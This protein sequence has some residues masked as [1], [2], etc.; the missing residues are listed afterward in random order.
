LPGQVCPFWTSFGWGVALAVPPSLA[1][2]AAFISLAGRDP[3]VVCLWETVGFGAG[4]FTFRI[5]VTFAWNVLDLLLIMGALVGLSVA[6]AG[7]GRLRVVA[8]ALATAGVSAWIT[9]AGAAVDRITRLAQ[10]PGLIA[11]RDGEGGRVALARVGRQLVLTIDGTAESVAPSEEVAEEEGLLPAVIHP[12]PRSFVV[13]GDPLGTVVE[14]LLTLG[15]VSIDWVEAVPGTFLALDAGALADGAARRAAGDRRVRVVRGDGRRSLA[16]L[17]RPCDVVVLAVGAPLSGSRARFYTREAMRQVGRILR[18]GGIVGLCLPSSETDPGPDLA[19]LQGR[20]VAAIGLEL[21][22]VRLIPGPRLLVQAGPGLAGPIDGRGAASRLARLSPPA[23]FLSA[24]RL[25]RLLD[26]QEAAGHL[27]YL[28]VNRSSSLEALL[29]SPAEALARATDSL[30]ELGQGCPSTDDDPACWR[31]ALP[32]S[33]DVQAGR[34]PTWYRRLLAWPFLRVGLGLA[35]LAA[36][37]ILA[38]KPAIALVS[39]VATTGLIAMGVETVLL[40]RLEVTSGAL[41]GEVALLGACYM[42]GGATGL[43]WAARRG[44]KMVIERITP[45]AGLLDAVL[46]GLCLAALAIPF[47]P[48]SPWTGL[49]GSGLALA[50]VGLVAAIQLWAAMGCQ[51]EGI[52]LDRAW[53]ADLAGAAAGVLLVLLVLITPFGLSRTLIALALL[54]VG[55]AIASW[56]SGPQPRR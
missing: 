1:L 41:M 21:G 30:V 32:L 52:G 53:A 34:V 43:A 47:D 29:V 3:V 12:D 33:L 26:P 39:S 31:A 11:S 17:D 9:Q 51:G 7:V 49:A 48:S 35:A 28:A 6:W 37:P 2:A 45:F 20:V 18:P 15:A 54:K 27:S 14:K 55:S 4:G 22:P 46:A 25:E 44:A 8:L 5:A 50:A 38:R 23:R 40:L 13:L 19:L 56:H 16:R 10:S 42:A 36:L 24:A